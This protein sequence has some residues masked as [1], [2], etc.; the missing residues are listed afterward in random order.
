M[1]KLPLV[2]F[3]VTSYNYS[4]FIEQTLESIK[5]QSYKNFE[6]IVVDDCSED[7]SVE[8]IERFIQFNQ[9]LRITLIKH[10]KNMGQF[11]SMLDGLK[12]ADGKFVSFV[13]SDD[14]L[15]EKYAETHM[16]VHLSTSVAF[17]CSQVAEID[18]NNEIHTTYSVASPQK[19]LAQQAKNLDE[20]LEVDSEKVEF[21]Q[22][23]GKRF[24]GWYW[25]PDSSAMFRKSAIEIVLNYKTP[26]RWRVCP[27]K[28]LF[29]FA[30]L[31]G[32][33]IVIYAP[34]VAYRRHSSNAG[35]TDYVCGDTKYNNDAATRRN[36]K[37]NIK[38][39]PDTFRFFV[40]NK[41]EFVKKFGTRGFLKFIFKV[42]F[43]A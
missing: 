36:I 19:G 35:G 42:I 22:L 3:V 10:D 23:K 43:G 34:L 37:N 31:T 25:S 39:R 6:I 27:D 33:S 40:E 28:F 18:E 12:I 7:N 4:N 5:N 21:E 17:T 16:R 24:G 2:T 13:D 11:A 30:H 20:L 8:V 38:I 29:N 15:L 14:V 32:G 26:E 41:D 9:D 1:L